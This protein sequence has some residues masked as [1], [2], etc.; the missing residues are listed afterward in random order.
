MPPIINEEKC[1]KCGYCA[2]ICPLDVIKV[3][4]DKKIVVNYPD[5]CWHC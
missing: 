5:E 4:K 2:A 1:I 3:S